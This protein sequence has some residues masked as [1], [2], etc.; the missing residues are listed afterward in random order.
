MRFLF[1]SF[2]AILILGCGEENMAT[3]GEEVER[4]LISTNVTDTTTFFDNTSQVI[5]PDGS[6]LQNDGKIYQNATGESI[7]I[8]SYV[9]G[10]NYIIGDTVYKDG[11]I[12]KV[13]NVDVIMVQKMPHEYTAV[14]TSYDQSNWTHRYLKIKR[15]LNKGKYPT[16]TH[17]IKDVLIRSGIFSTNG[18]KW[19]ELDDTNNRI[20]EYTLTSKY[21]LST[22]TATGA[23]LAT[24]ATM[25]I[26]IR[27]NISGT[28]FIVYDYANKRLESY[29]LNYGFDLS[30]G[31]FDNKTYN[32]QD[33]TPTDFDINGDGTIIMEVGLD[34]GKV[35]KHFLNTGF[36]LTTASY[37]NISWNLENTADLQI[38]FH[39]INNKMYLKGEA[40]GP[41]TKFKEYTLTA[42]FDISSPSLSKVQYLSENGSVFNFI[43]QDGRM[44]FTGDYTASGAMK[45]FVYPYVFDDQWD[46]DTIFRD[47]TPHHKYDNRS[48]SIYTFTAILNAPTDAYWYFQSLVNGVGTISTQIPRI[49]YLDDTVLEEEASLLS[50]GSWFPSAI[51][52][53]DEGL[54]IRTNVDTSI[55][56]KEINVYE[57]SIVTS[58]S[59][60]GFSYVSLNNQ[61]RPFDDENTS[62]AVSTSPMS[63]TLKGLG[64]FNSFTLSRVLASNL[65]YKF[66]L[67]ALDENYGLWLDGIQVASGGNGVVS[68]DTVT[69]DCKRDKNGI[70]TL[71]PTTVMFY[72]KYEIS[73]G[74]YAYYQMPTGS[75]V[76]ITLTHSSDVYLAGF[77]I[78]NSIQLGITKLSFGHGQQ[79][80]N[81]YEPD[82]FGNIAQGVKP[83]RTKFSIT[84]IL[85]TDDYDYAIAFLESIKTKFLSIDGSDSGMATPDGKVFKSLTRRVL[86]T[87]TTPSTI[88][89]D[90]DISKMSDVKI[91]VME[92]V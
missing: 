77:T 51:I 76:E 82:A 35:Y 27:T 41:Y 3:I 57:F 49:S 40:S 65:T 42:N 1:I 5:Y 12:E 62:S 59:E 66:I 61:N 92:V 26:R 23:I 22:K 17:E 90:G 70:L 58:P 48:G 9:E 4:E 47:I 91:S 39:P 63:Y 79:D 54:Y 16:A 52:E 18:L 10:E 85:Y 83:V 20:V 45:T 72:A 55:E 25:P 13:T 60:I 43:T 8:P 71:Y 84:S 50:N 74:V 78:N 32:L 28:K 2:L 31:S 64:E 81:S 44:F 24:N 80:W 21:D 67:D 7:I 38:N 53:T 75:T 11:H 56:Y 29:T 36:D 37:T 30:T 34:G 88:E 46:S 87:N 89:K 33:N 69:I 68:L 86:V 15:F 14:D 19:F 73:A 6:R